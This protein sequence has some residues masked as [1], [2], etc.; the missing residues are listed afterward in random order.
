[1]PAIATDVRKS[2]PLKSILSSEDEN[3]LALSVLSGYPDRVAQWRSS[4]ARD[5]GRGEVALSVEALLSSMK[6]S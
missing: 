3:S 6:A 1:M 2:S 4:D 5:R